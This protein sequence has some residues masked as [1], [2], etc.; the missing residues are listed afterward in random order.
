[1]STGN[2]HGARSAQGQGTAAVQAVLL[3]VLVLAGLAYGVIET[4][5]NV[6]NLFGG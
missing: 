3:W 4:A 1:M 2:G 5:K 6:A